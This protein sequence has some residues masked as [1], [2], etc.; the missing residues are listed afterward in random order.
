[1]PHCELVPVM[2]K[3]L[4]SKLHVSAGAAAAAATAQYCIKN[5]DNTTCLIAHWLPVMQNQLSSDSARIC[6]SRSSSSTVWHHEPR[7]H[8]VQLRTGACH[9]EPAQL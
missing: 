5:P 6:R 3:Q 1:M 2:K 4:S 7:Q 8:D 9:E